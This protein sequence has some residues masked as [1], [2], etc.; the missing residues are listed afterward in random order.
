MDLNSIA[1]PPAPALPSLAWGGAQALQRLRHWVPVRTLAERHRPAVRT[2]LRALSAEDRQRRFGHS[3]SDERVRAYA[4]QLDF[5]L[6]LIFGVFDR[7]LRLVALGHL[8]L[9]QGADPVTGQG[10]GELGL[11]VL[12]SAR[13]QRLGSQL[14]EHAVTHA[15][16]RGVH[17]LHIHL[18]RDNAPMLA[19]VQAAGAHITHQGHEAQALLTLPGLTLGSQLDELLGARAAELDFRLKVQSLRVPAPTRGTSPPPLG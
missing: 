3:L 5:N 19:I 7:R 18:A 16:N 15:R 12:A 10:H 17:S 4:D 11:S 2:H 6:D 9:A 13:G 1:L 14:F 8:A